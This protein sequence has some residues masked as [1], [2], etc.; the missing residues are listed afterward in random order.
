MPSAIQEHAPP[1][2]AVGFVSFDLYANPDGMA[3]SA[4]G[5]VR[6]HWTNC[7]DASLAMHW[8]A[9]ARASLTKSAR[10]PSTGKPQAAHGVD[11]G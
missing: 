6:L 3:W 8:T 2:P 1:G 11:E 7:S 4:E 9:S 10:M 5:T